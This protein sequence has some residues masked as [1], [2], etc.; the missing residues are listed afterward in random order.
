MAT[1]RFLTRIDRS[2]KRDP[3][4]QTIG[5]LR[6]KL[7]SKSLFI[8]LTALRRIRK[9]IEASG[10]RRGYFNLAQPLTLDTD[11]TCRWQATIIVGECIEDDPERVWRVARRLSM[12]LKADVRAAAATVLLEHLLQYHPKTMITRLRR[13][14]RRGDEHFADALGSCWNFGSGANKARIQK[15]L[16]EASEASP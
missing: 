6:Q 15:L 8:R 13:E 3:T 16:D 14:L 11:S 5:Q 2:I 1:T 7:R 10:L 9:Q 12:S 4:P